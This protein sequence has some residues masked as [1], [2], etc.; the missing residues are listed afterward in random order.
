L[1]SVNYTG[2]KNQW[3]PNDPVHRCGQAPGT[4]C[5]EKDLES[6][7]KGVVAYGL[8]LLERDGNIPGD[9]FRYYLPKGTTAAELTLFGLSGDSTG[10]TLARL[11]SPPTS[12]F[13]DNFDQ[14]NDLTKNSTTIKTERLVCD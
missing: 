3:N 10:A 1:H 5:S 2:F 11:G 12:K 13:P 4:T 9:L 14:F 7:G 6:H 8:T